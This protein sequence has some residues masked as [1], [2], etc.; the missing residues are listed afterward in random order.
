MAIRRAMTMVVALVVSATFA[1]SGVAAQQA[2]AKQ[3]TKKRSKQEQ[4]EIDTVVKLV[5]MRARSTR[6]VCMT[7]VHSSRHA[8]AKPRI[9]LDN[10]SDRADLMHNVALGVHLTLHNAGS[11]LGAA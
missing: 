4:Q 10:G 5:V 7:C 8:I 9:L 1:V 11:T 2:Q 6:R 3:D